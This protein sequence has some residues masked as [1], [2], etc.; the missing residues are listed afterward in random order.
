MITALHASFRERAEPSSADKIA[1]TRRFFDTPQPDGR[2]KRTSPIEEL[3][4]ARLTSLIPAAKPGQTAVD[5]GCHWGRY[6]RFLGQTYD[7]VWGIDFAAA[8]VGSAAGAPNIRYRVM[9][10]E[11]ATQQFAFDGRVDLI[12][13]IGLFEMLREPALLCVRLGAVAGPGCRALIVIPNRNCIHFVV[14][15]AL[16]WLARNLLG[17]RGV[18]IHH[19]GSQIEDVVRWMSEG[20]FTLASRGATVGLPPSVLGRLPSWIQ[21][22]LLPFDRAALALLGGSYDW[23]LMERENVVCR[24]C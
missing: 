5:L 2:P 9:D 3:V 7:A 11:D 17:R 1:K 13:A 22:G 12:L 19:N 15:R 23:V 4:F 16:L 21:K 18:Y 24:S 20:G 10:L 14:L 8:A 6:T